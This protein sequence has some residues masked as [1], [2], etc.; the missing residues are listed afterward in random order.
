MTKTDYIFL[1]LI[2]VPMVLG[3]LAVGILI[4]K[5]T[6]KYWGEDDKDFK[7]RNGY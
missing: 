7:K 5:D 1:L 3:S 6:I 2:I 4:L